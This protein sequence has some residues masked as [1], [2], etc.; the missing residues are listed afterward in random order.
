[1]F[2]LGCFHNGSSDLPVIYN[3]EGLTISDGSLVDAHAA[4]QRTTV[5]QVRQ[6]ILA[7]KLG[8]DYWFQT[9]HHFQPE[10]AE[11]SPN[12]LLSETAIAAHTHRIRLG[13]T[14]NIITWHHPVRLAEQIAMLDVLSGGRV[15][16]GI[17]R[18]YQPRENETLGRPYGSTI[19]DQ[20]RNR[21]AFEE[22][23]EIIIKC[24]TE[25]SFSHRGENFSIPPRYTKWNHAHTK[26]YFA[27]EKV[28]RGIEDIL[29]LGGP[30]SYAG[31][32]PVVATTTTLKEISVFPQPI[33]KP[34]P[35]LWQPLTSPRSIRWAAEHGVNG[36]FVGEANDQL[37]KNIEI[38]YDAAEKAKWPD[39]LGR[40]AL[41]YGWDAEK[42]RGVGIARFIHPILPGR[43]DARERERLK[44]G[45]ELQFDYIGPF[46][47]GL[48]LPVGER[49]TAEMLIEGEIALVGKPDELIE[50]IMKLKE[51]C[52]YEDLMFAGLFE[53]AGFEGHEIED[54]MQYFAE[55]CAPKLRDA[56]GGSPQRDT[57]GVPELVPELGSRAEKSSLEAVSR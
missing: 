32:N 54:L 46:F 6:G 16:C 45:L 52:G 25:L 29:K 3:A 9:E 30:D 48:L 31:G 14:A 57:S 17:G 55:E 18:G 28:E 44:R 51:A 2:E 20:E 49:V 41:R 23:F 39:R 10:G 56:C 12:P 22:A 7:E 19:Q 21:A 36:Y 43:D 24:W 50:K 42:R 4:A 53:K 1:M 35:Q 27:Q 26:A 38:Y 33:Q 40:G 34:H 8:Y 13:Q 5:N 47:E 11:F 37:A 15:E